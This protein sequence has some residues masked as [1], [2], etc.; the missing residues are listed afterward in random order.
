MPRSPVNTASSVSAISSETGGPGSEGQKS[1]L[2]DDS[3][4]DSDVEDDERILEKSKDGRW[5]KINHQV[6]III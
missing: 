2:H 3:E 4:P 1:K 6:I 5:Q